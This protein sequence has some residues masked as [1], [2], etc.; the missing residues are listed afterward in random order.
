MRCIQNGGDCI[1][2][3]RATSATGRDEYGG[4]DE[5]EE[6]M[7]HEQGYVEPSDSMKKFLTDYC[8]AGICWVC[9]APLK[10]K[11]T[12]CPGGAHKGK[13]KKEEE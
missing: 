5:K 2:R 11:G 12:V 10:E 3:F 6:R 8:Y 9:G 13:D 1:L 7:A 4:S